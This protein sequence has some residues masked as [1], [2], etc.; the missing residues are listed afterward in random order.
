M[1]TSRQKIAAEVIRI[2]AEHP[3]MPDDQVHATV[4]SNLGV[5]V[6]QVVDVLNETQEQQS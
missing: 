1:I 5:L 6:E 2:A 4:A 3:G